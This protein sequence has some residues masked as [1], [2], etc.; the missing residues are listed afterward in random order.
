MKYIDAERCTSTKARSSG[1]HSAPQVLE[2]RTST[3]WN[4]VSVCAICGR[5]P[6]RAKR[7]RFSSSVQRRA[8]SPRTRNAP[9]R[10][11]IPLSMTRN[12]RSMSMISPTVGRVLSPLA[13]A[14]RRSAPTTSH[15]VG[16][17]ITASAIPPTICK[18]SLL[19]TSRR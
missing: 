13:T 2:D 6:I 4:R 18:D 15:R 17:P 12:I 11:C 19:A 14:R 3:K 1:I 7:R 8:T 9:C 5:I 10:V 16:S